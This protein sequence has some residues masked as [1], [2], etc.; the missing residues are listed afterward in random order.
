MSRQQKGFSY[1]AS[2]IIPVLNEAEQLP[3]FLADLQSLRDKGCELILVDGGSSDASCTLATGLVDQLLES[4]A[5]RAIQLNRGAAAA[6][7]EW[8]FFL[9]ADTRLTAASEQALLALIERDKACW[10]RFDVCIQGKHPLLWLVARMMNLRSC[11]TGMAT[12]DQLMFVHR[13]LFDAVQGFVEQPLM[14]DI[15]LSRCLKKIC[16]P[17]CLPQRVITSGRRW[18]QRGF[19]S[20]VVLMW[21]LRWCYWRGVAAEQ[22][23]R[24]YR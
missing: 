20:T 9:H 11:L 21:R 2:I 1:K 17:L 15:E 7:G 22:L 24:E 14:E 4:P 6:C 18:D 16:R 10:G 13:C 12:G 5:G 23:A 8:L 19:W 3:D